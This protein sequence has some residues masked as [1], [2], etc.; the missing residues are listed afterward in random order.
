MRN[1]MVKKPFARGTIDD[2]IDENQ[3]ISNRPP[4]RSAAE[5]NKN[6]GR[7]LQQISSPGRFFEIALTLSPDRGSERALTDIMHL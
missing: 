5:K 2:T 7:P 3:L 1:G 6:K 4:S